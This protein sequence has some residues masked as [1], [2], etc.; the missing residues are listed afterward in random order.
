[1]LQ[2][3]AFERFFF[4]IVCTYFTF[5]QLSKPIV[6]GANV[7]YLPFEE[8][9]EV[10]GTVTEFAGW[11][12]TIVSKKTLKVLIKNWYFNSENNLTARRVTY[13]RQNCAQSQVWLFLLTVQPFIQ[14][15]NLF[16]ITCCALAPVSSSYIVECFSEK[17][18]FKIDT[19]H[20]YRLSL[21]F[22]RGISIGSN[23]RWD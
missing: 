11:G 3:I 19:S 8:A 10:T 2:V 21:P 9:E 15:M 4:F 20:W 6:Y 17:F 7:E 14:Q 1:M 18:K 23:N 13:H 22:W 16:P 5:Q 12:G